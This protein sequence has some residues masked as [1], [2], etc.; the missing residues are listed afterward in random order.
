MQICFALERH[1][2]L[3]I[4]SPRRGHHAADEESL[5]GWFRGVLPWGGEVSS[6]WVFDT[7]GLLLGIDNIHDVYELYDPLEIL[8]TKDIMHRVVER[9]VDSFLVIFSR[10]IGAATLFF[11][12]NDLYGHVN[13]VPT[14][15]RYGNGL[16]EDKDD[17]GRPLHL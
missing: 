11:Y 17:M 13:N 9:F 2:T 15:S 7:G 8:S 3:T 10:A 4:S 1:P 16:S 12:D 5:I 6:D 14:G